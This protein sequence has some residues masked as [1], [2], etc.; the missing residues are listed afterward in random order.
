MSLEF[1]IAAPGYDT[2]YQ[3]RWKLTT[4]DV[5]PDETEGEIGNNMGQRTV[6]WMPITPGTQNA[7]VVFSNQQHVFICA[8]SADVVVAPA[9]P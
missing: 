8:A 5:D 4:S 2:N 9:N 1:E 7:F 3:M 6:N